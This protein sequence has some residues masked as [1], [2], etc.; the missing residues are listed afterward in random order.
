MAALNLALAPGSTQPRE[1]GK[2]APTWLGWWLP[3]ARE[4]PGSI[5]DIRGAWW[6]CLLGPGVLER[7]HFLIS[8]SHGG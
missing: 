4:K 1:A 2:G 6:H 8:T 3:G 7:T 5:L